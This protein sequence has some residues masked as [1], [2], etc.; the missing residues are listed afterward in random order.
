MYADTKG[1]TRVLRVL[2]PLPTIPLGMT[3]YCFYSLACLFFVVVAHQS[4][5][6]EESKAF[7]QWV[8]K[9]RSWGPEPLE[10]PDPTTTKLP[11]LWAELGDELTAGDTINA[12]DYVDR[13]R[14]YRHLVTKINHCEWDSVEPNY[15]GN[16]IWGLPLQHSWQYETA[17]LSVGSEE[18]LKSTTFSPKAWWGCMNYYLSVIPY[19]LCEMSSKYSCVVALNVRVVPS[20]W[21]VVWGQS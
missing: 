21:S 19:F 13:Q 16:I 17:R 5:T 3:F 2:E 12:W 11:L 7:L 6:Y 20:C 1:D 15:W 10:I 8:E 9:L 18:G 4:N 14:L